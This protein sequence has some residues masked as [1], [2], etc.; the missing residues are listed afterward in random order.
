MAN[1]CKFWNFRKRRN[2]TALPTDD[3][4]HEEW[5]VLFKL[6]TDIL[7]PT[8]EVHNDG[9]LQYN[10]CYIPFFGRYYFFKNVETIAKDQYLIYLEIDVA[11]T[12][13]E[14][15]KGQTVLLG[16]A[17]YDYDTMLDDARVSPTGIYKEESSVFTM[18][19][20]FSQSTTLILEFIH[21]KGL[22]SGIEFGIGASLKD[23]LE[24]IN[25]LDWW[26]SLGNALAGGINPMGN[27]LNAWVIPYNVELTNG[28][29]GAQVYSMYGEGF[30]VQNRVASITPAKHVA[31]LSFPASPYSDFRGCDKY[32]EYVL[33][34]PGVGAIKIPYSIATSGNS[35][36]LN[37]C[38]DCISGDIAYGVYVGD[39][40]IGNYSANYRSDIPIAGAIQ[41]ANGKT[42][43]AIAS[44][45]MGGLS[46]A[47]G[48]M[49]NSAKA[50]AGAI[51]GGMAVGAVTGAFSG[52]ASAGGF[53][54]NVGEATMT[55]IGAL[56]GSVAGYRVGVR[57]GNNI[58]EAILTM[59]AHGTTYNPANYTALFGRPSNRVSTIKDGFLQ[60]VG[61]SVTISGTSAER[62]MLNGLLNGGLYY[63]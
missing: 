35:L 33:S 57:S 48:G 49:P 51:A 54:S 46:G 5:N 19:S 25:D 37:I 23:Y 31:N 18:S 27:F 1:I 45:L 42:A 60:S 13:K 56:S 32:V 58:P 20:I 34:L 12:F 11:G 24:K 10:Y 50:S 40:C 39:I 8:L 14:E 43:T 9:V 26:D 55:S 16:L 3:M 41:S 29:A 52:Y 30:S 53:A 38:A 6:D 17:S 7:A 2:S 62:D 61:A 44:G 28:L 47:L 4:Q 59:R 15:I 21:E 63:E 22:H 36:T